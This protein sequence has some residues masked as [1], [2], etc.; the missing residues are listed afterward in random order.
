MNAHSG[1]LPLG[2]WLSVTLQLI[3]VLKFFRWE[4]GYMCSMDIQVD[5][6]GYYLCWGCLVWVPSAYTSH[7]FYLAANATDVGPWTGAAIAVGGWTMIWMNYDCD[8]QRFLFRQTG[9]ECTILGRKPE[10]ITARYTTEG[11]EEKTSLLLLSGWWG[12]SKVRQGA[13]LTTLI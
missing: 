11:G 12:V 5:R 7:A 2:V 8:W 1:V 6:A 9:G 4:M 3:Y 13:P 10:Y